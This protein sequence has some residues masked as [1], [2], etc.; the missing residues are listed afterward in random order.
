ME[1]LVPSG[2]AFNKNLANGGVIVLV[3]NLI[4]FVYKRPLYP[5]YPHHNEIDYQVLALEALKLG[6]QLVCYSACRP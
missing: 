5:V 6:G 2:K 3:V 1:Y 4:Q